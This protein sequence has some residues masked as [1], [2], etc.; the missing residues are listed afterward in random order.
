MMKKLRKWI[1]K[2]K[3]VAW[4]RVIH[5][6]LKQVDTDKL[7]EYKPKSVYALLGDWSIEILQFGFLAWLCYGIFL[8]DWSVGGIVGFGVL[9]WLIIDFVKRLS[10]AVRG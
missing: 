5:E 9:Y 6:R 2:F 1:K 8:G 4:G 7:E 3:P 10:G